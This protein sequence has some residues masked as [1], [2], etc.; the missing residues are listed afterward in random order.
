MENR[1]EKSAMVDNTNAKSKQITLRKLGTNP[2]KDYQV[3]AFAARLAFEAEGL[4]GIID[5]RD[6]DPTPPEGVIDADLQARIDKWKRDHGRV[7]DAII[8]ALET[9]HVY[10]IWSVKDSARGIWLR[11]ESEFGVPLDIEFIRASKNLATLQRDSKD[12]I[13]QHINKFERYLREANFNRPPGSTVDPSDLSIKA[14]TNLTFLG[15]L[16]GGDDP[17]SKKWETFVQATGPRIRQMTIQQLYAEVHANEFQKPEKPSTTNPIVDAKALQTSIDSLASRISDAQGRGRSGRGGRGKRGHKGGNRGRGGR[18]GKGNKN[19][20]KGDGEGGSK[21]ENDSS[22]WCVRHAR[23]GHA[24]ENCWTAAKEAKDAGAVHSGRQQSTSDRTYQPSFSR[25]YLYSPRSVQVVR[26]VNSTEMQ[27][28]DDPYNW[29][30]DTAA[31]CYITPYKDTLR[32]YVEFSEPEIVRGFRGR[33]E[34]ATGKGSV[35]LFDFAGNRLTLDN[36][37]YVSGTPDQIFSLMKFRREH[38]GG[39]KFTAIEEFIIS[40][41]NGFRINWMLSQRHL[42]YVVIAY[43]ASKCCGNS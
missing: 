12:T 35:T 29:V 17:E 4:D 11:L 23:F 1:A 9:E 30:V 40:T 25:P 10:K 21:P 5:G 8:Q 6:T 37:V 41:P 28:T 3:W 33:T 13:D 22:K 34:E 16:I 27:L 32:N 39:F 42:S 31:N 15:S 14:V 19:H 24:T 2:S 7:K 20:P 36:V 18:G 43:N 26:L 38:V